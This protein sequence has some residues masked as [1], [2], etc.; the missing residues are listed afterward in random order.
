M[1]EWSAEASRQSR[2]RQE[3][4]KLA[5][6]KSVRD[7]QT[8]DNGGRTLWLDLRSLMRHKCEEFNG[9][10]GNVGI[11]SLTGMQSSVSLCCAAH[12]ATIDGS[13]SD[14]TVHFSGKNGVEY[15]VLLSVRLTPNGVETWLADS[16]GRPV[17]PDVLANEA[18]DT[19]LRASGR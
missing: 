18:I 5:D 8:L 19:L 3:V 14:N 2:E 13:F 7:K 6:E 1:S 10:P 4:R 16:A 12:Q 11:L 15:E 17:V 9:E